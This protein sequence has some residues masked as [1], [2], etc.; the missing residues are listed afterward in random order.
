MTLIIDPNVGH[1][2]WQNE[3]GKSNVAPMDNESA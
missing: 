1:K 3:L 2:W